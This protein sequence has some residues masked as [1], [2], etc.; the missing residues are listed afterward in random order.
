M[1]A[2]FILTVATAIALIAAPVCAL[3]PSQQGTAAAKARADAL[4]R[5]R[6]A[7]EAKA[8]ADAQAAA[9]AK[10]DAA[11]AAQRRAAVETFLRG[12]TAARTKVVEAKPTY[13]LA[14][15]ARHST[16]VA[17]HG[18]PATPLGARA[19]IYRRHA[20]AALGRHATTA[21]GHSR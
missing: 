11:I 6:L 18:A 14:N 20:A 10:V 8:R 21:S 9:R 17:A 1:K 19:P 5:A 2:G 13:V 4:A 3:T 7:A 15:V 12:Q 16:S